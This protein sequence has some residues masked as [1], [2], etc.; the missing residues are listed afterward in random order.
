M[1]L[2][3]NKIFQQNRLRGQFQLILEKKFIQENNLNQFI[4]QKTVNFTKI[5]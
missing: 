4:L 3:K 2:V 1:S 5:Y